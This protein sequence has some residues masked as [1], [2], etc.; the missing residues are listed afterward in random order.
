MTKLTTVKFFALI[1]CKLLT[2]LISCYLQ[3]QQV[4]RTNWSVLLLTKFSTVLQRW[5]QQLPLSDP[6]KIQNAESKLSNHSCWLRYRLYFSSF[7]TLINYK[8]SHKHVRKKL[9]C[10]PLLLQIKLTVVFLIF[11]QTFCS[12]PLQTSYIDRKKESESPLLLLNW[13]L[14]RISTLVLSLILLET[15]TIGSK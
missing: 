6:L 13:I 15:P 3:I 12:N 11:F 14:L 8:L 9:N 10:L 2:T 5:L 1:H 4:I 7:F